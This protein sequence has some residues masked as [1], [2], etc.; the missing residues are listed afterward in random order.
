MGSTTSIRD[1]RSKEESTTFLKNDFR[2]EGRLYTLCS[3]H[4]QMCSGMEL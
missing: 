3:V 2:L 4:I 1:L